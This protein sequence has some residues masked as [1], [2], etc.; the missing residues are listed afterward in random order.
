MRCSL[1]PIF[2]CNFH[3][4]HIFQTLDYWF[5][6]SHSKVRIAHLYPSP[7]SLQDLKVNTVKLT[8][9]S[10][11]PFLVRTVV[12]VKLGSTISGRE[13]QKTSTYMFM[14]LDVSKCM[15]IY[16]V[17]GHIEQHFCLLTI[18]C[19]MVIWIFSFKILQWSY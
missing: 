13:N 10:A 14:H 5:W 9:M 8:W 19:A 2:F 4:E 18:C 17:N 7:L 11:S 1:P 6:F 16:N 15:H 12:T 3:Y